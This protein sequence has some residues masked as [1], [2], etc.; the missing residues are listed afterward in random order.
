MII[1][2]PIMSSVPH[3]NLNRISLN[4]LITNWRTER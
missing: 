3:P 4:T 1:F 2:S